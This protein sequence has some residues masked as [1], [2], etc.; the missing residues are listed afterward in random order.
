MKAFVATLAGAT[1]T[2][3]MLTALPAAAQETSGDDQSIIVEADRPSSPKEVRSLARKLGANIDLLRP[4]PRF[5]DPLCLDVGGLKDEYQERFTRRVLDNAR[6]AGVWVGKEGCRPN[7]MVMFVEDSRSQLKALRKTNRFLFGNMPRSAFRDMLES[8]DGVYAW[9]INE[10]TSLSQLPFDSASQLG[11]GIPANRTI[12]VGRL[13]PPIRIA[14][15]SSVVVIEK[16][17]TSGK[18]PE[19][20]ADYAT[21]RLIAPT[22]ELEESGGSGPATIMT[23]FSDPMTAPEGLTALDTAYL[24]SVY[25]IRV[26]GPSG[27]LFAQTAL[28]MDAQIGD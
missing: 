16:D 2:G 21:M 13:N 5:A 25:K 10:V 26:N 8:R 4:I 22:V 11:I 6:R 18:T 20:L 7:A 14:T 1:L 28:Q 12:E 24:E 15:R 17:R 19:Q 9:Q 27:R 3:T 23:L